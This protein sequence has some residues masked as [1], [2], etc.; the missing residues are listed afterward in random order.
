MI[1]ELHKCSFCGAKQSALTLTRI[2][3]PVLTK[4]DP[5]KFAGIVIG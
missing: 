5:P 3:P 2:A 4:T 1:Q